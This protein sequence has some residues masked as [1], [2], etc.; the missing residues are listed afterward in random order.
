MPEKRSK[1]PQ[2]TPARRIIDYATNEF[3]QKG[4][5]QVTMDDIAKGLQMSKRTL[6]QIFSDKECLVIACIQNMSDL[7][8]NLVAEMMEKGKNTL[9]IILGII[10]YRLKSIEHVSSQYITDIAKHKAVSDYIQQKREEK[11]VQTVLFLEQGIEQGFFRKDTNL[12]LVMIS[13][14]M[15][16]EN[17]ISIVD[18]SKTSVQE[19]FINIGLFHLR[20]CCTPR[21]I[22]L[23]DNFLEHYRT[24][25]H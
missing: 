17:L 25:T 1:F 7:E 16:M 18:F 10:E 20:G 23:I 9:E 22:E 19:C 2:G 5:R 8:H 24:Q 14:F 4:L 15:N 12:Q 13:I 11:I 3:L 6:Y 21:G